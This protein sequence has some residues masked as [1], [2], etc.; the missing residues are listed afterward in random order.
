MPTACATARVIGKSYPAFVPSASIDVST[1]SPAPNS[2][3]RRAQTTASSPV[4]S[5]PPL[6]W[7]SQTS[8]P[9]CHAPGID[10]NNRGAGAE[11]AGYRRDEL[12]R[13]H[14][15]GIDAHFLRPGLDQ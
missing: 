9:L 14:G 6:M 1:L 2:S 5:R 12:G 13:P 15:R 8:R 10:V 4:G 3:T 7:T 11:F